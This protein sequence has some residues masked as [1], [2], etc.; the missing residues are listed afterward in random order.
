MQIRFSNPDLPKVSF[1]ETITLD[2]YLFQSD[3]SRYLLPCMCYISAWKR[4]AWTTS[5]TRQVCILARCPGVW[6]LYPVSTS[7]GWSTCCRSSFSLW[8][9]QIARYAQHQGAINVYT[10][11]LLSS[12]DPTPLARISAQDGAGTANLTLLDIMI[13]LKK[14]YGYLPAAELALELNKLEQ[15]FAHGMSIFYGHLAMHRTVYM[16]ASTNDQPFSGHQQMTYYLY[17]SLRK[18]Q[19]FHHVALQMYDRVY[20]TLQQRTLESLVCPPGS[21]TRL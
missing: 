11:V 15:P 17:E 5:N 19:P 9:R 8:Q 14:L 7:W 6:C 21:N 12:L 3:N 2:Y 13:R 18:F 4:F 20:V 10:H 1:Q 16:A